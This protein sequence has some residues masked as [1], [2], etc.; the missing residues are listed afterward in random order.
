V[1]DSRKM[2]TILPK[3]IILVFMLSRVETN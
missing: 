1:S 2:W 3:L